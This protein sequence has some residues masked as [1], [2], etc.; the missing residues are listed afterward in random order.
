MRLSANLRKQLLQ[1]RRRR[2]GLTL[3]EMMVVIILIGVLATVVYGGFTTFLSSSKE[4]LAKLSMTQMEQALNIYKMKKNKFPKSLQDAEKYM[5]DGGVPQDPWGNDF[6]YSTS[7]SCGTAYEIISYGTDG[8]K[9][10]GDDV[11][12][13][14]EK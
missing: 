1:A 6:Q 13:C 3:A 4:D 11:S 8:Q 12:S 14:P 2:R 7:S 10:G 5:K 9:G